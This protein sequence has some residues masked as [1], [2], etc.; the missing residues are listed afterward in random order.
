M[1]AA[2]LA[3]MA[4]VL[5]AGQALAF[6]ADEQ[7]PD[8]AQEKRAR[9]ISGSLRCLV[10]QNQSILDSEAPLARDLR[11]LVRERVAAGDSDGEV[12]DFIVE[13]Y[14]DWVLLKPPFKGYTYL[15]WFG[16]LILFVFG[17]I[18]V[19]VYFRRS[20]AA[21]APTAPPLSAE[22]QARLERLLRG[23]GDSG[24]GGKS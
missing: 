7:L 12:R 24:D 13:R 4:A 6:S 21:G 11:E 18:G 2:L 16:P 22:E 1:R 15:L 17:A 23:D 19:F 3:L 10:C 5:L 9:E 14:G 8:S 20:A